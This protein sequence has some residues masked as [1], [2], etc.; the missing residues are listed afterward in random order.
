MAKFS[1]CKYLL[2]FDAL[3]GWWWVDLLDLSGFQWDSSMI[4]FCCYTHWSQSIDKPISF[5]FFF[6]ILFRFFLKKNCWG[7]QSISFL[8]FFDLIL[9]FFKKI[10]DEGDF[11][12]DDDIY[13]DRCW[14]SGVAVSLFHQNYTTSPSTEL[15]YPFFLNFYS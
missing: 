4:W 3:I 15:I 14:G 8:L 5:L 12:C 11:W 2:D 9:I 1:I 6:L 7:S 13:M 10:V